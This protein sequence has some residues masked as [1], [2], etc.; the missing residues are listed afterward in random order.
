MLVQEI[1]PEKFDEAE[2]AIVNQFCDD[3]LAG[4]GGSFE[5]WLVLRLF[6]V[7]NKKKK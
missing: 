4:F 6:Y 3:R 2:E 7:T 5:R 1:T